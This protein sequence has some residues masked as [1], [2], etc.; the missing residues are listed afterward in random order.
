VYQGRD[1]PINTRTLIL[2]AGRGLQGV[3]KPIN[4]VSREP[5]R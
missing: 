5:I 2:R 3:L 1:Y 4:F